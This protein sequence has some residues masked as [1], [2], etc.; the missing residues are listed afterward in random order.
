M[1]DDD[2]RDDQ[3]QTHSRTHPLLPPWCGLALHFAAHSLPIG[4]SANQQQSILR[5]AAAAAAGWSK[6]GAPFEGGEKT[7]SACKEALP[8]NQAQRLDSD[9]EHL[10]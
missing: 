5:T 7:L 8:K 9:T 1:R 4:Q 2:A 10:M 6:V 3:Q